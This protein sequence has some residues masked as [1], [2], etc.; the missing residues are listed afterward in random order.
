MSIFLVAL[1]A[2]AILLLIA[3]PGYILVKKNLVSRECVPV[4]SKLLLP[5]LA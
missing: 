2:V 1:I 5:L 4:F 3:S